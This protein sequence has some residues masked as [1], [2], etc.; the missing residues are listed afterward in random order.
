M[1]ASGDHSLF[2]VHAHINLL[3][4]VS[5]GLFTYV[6]D[7]YPELGGNRLARLHFWLYNLALPVMLAALT[8]ML[9]GTASMQPVVGIFSIAVGVAVVIFALNVFLN[10]KGHATAD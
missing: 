5:M 7:R 6:Y 1:G 3:G 8:S 4:W 10:V 2:P 9:K